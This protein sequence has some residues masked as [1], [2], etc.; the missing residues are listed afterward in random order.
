MC[1]V[2]FGAAVGAPV[3][4]NHRQIYCATPGGLRLSLRIWG[5]GPPQLLL[6]HGFGDNALVWQHFV[7]TFSEELSAVAIDLRGHG[8]SDWDPAGVYAPSDMVADLVHV[9][10]ELCS[11]TLVIVGHSLG[12]QV[13]IHAAAARRSLISAAV[14]V[15]LAIQPSE[16][17][18]QYVRGKFRERL[19]EHATVADYVALLHQQLPLAREELLLL[20]AEGALRANADGRFDVRCDP[21][22]GQ[23]DDSVDALSML[24]SLRQLE[25]PIL[26]VRGA[27]S[28]VLSHA[29]ALELLAQLP[30]SRL[31]AVPTAGHAVMLDN[32][33]GFSTAVR[34]YVLRFSSGLTGTAQ[35]SLPS[36][37]KETP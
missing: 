27:G 9:I 4:P 13:G 18:F 24:A 21:L 2:A 35:W 7:S 37:G 32:P 31:T 33:D 19:R 26:F 6:V 15:D 34:P 22:L 29:T 3:T 12:A 10:D 8:D 23:M 28:A 36:R 11:N 16:L 5:C 14:L 1:S 25:R 20:L 30:Q 17:S